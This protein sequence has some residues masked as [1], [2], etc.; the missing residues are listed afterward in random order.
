M[1]FENLK[2]SD[3]YSLALTPNPSPNGRGVASPPSPSGRRGQGDEGTCA[4]NLS[5][6]IS[7]RSNLPCAL[8]EIASP[9]RGSQ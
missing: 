8:M 5:K 4:F 2:N 6:F 1:N 3:T 9:L 7:P